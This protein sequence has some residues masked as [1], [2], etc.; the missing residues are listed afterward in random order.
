M[1]PIKFMSTSCEFAL[2]WMPQNTFDHKSTLT[3]IMVWCWHLLEPVLTKVSVAIWCHKA[4]HIEL[5]H[6]GWVMHICV[7]ELWHRCFQVMTLLLSFIKVIIWNTAGTL[8]IGPLGTNFNEILI[9]IHTFW[10]RKIYL[11][12]LSGKWQPFCL[13]LNVLT[14]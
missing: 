12:M 6:W 5:T 3:Q 10:G 11:K 2:R 7:S 9:E 4:T 14:H 8:L 1:S 13:G